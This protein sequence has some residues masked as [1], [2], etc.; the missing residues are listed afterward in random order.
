MFLSYLKTQKQTRVSAIKDQVS[1]Y[2]PGEKVSASSECEYL[3]LLIY[4]TGFKI[5]WELET[6]LFSKDPNYIHV[7]WSLFVHLM[8]SIID[9]YF[10]TLITKNAWILLS[11]ITL[12][13]TYFD[14]ILHNPHT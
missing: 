5:I 11:I 10:I 4:Q 2:C 1:S 7:Y 12:K 3:D 9:I 6:I 13:A 14:L 8:L